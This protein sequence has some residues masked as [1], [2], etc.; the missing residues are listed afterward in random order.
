M[1]RRRRDPLYARQGGVKL[2]VTS[3]ATGF[4]YVGRC[5]THLH[6]EE[7]PARMV[8]VDERC[9]APAC[10]LAWPASLRIVG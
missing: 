8:P 10:R 9:Q 6:G 5:G 4:P 2:H 7:Y 1:S 3:D